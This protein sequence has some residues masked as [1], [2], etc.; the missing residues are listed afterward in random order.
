MNPG[1]A[2]AG[3]GTSSGT[4]N[5]VLRAFTSF[6]SNG[7]QKLVD[8]EAGVCVALLGYQYLKLIVEIGFTKRV[9][10]QALFAFIISLVWYQVARNSVAVVQVWMAFAGRFG[11][12]FSGGNLDG[13][14]MENPSLFMDLGWDALS[15]L[16]GQSTSF[17]DILAAGSAWVMFMIIGLLIWASFCLLGF[18]AVYVSIRCS[19]E[20]M[21][22]LALL[23]FV[24]VRETAF[25]AAAGIGMIVNAWVKLSGTSI[26]IGVSYG[27]VQT[28]KL[29][30]D[31]TIRQGA[32]LLVVAAACVLISGG[33]VM[34]RAAL[35]ALRVL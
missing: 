35:G 17:T 9:A 20:V 1:D 14:V 26:A 19:L 5:Y 30:P 33:V 28:I 27:V 6:I 31:A 24:I 16:V 21:I 15:R 13:N 8:L 29:P 12:I 10:A 32:E 7:G 34:M 23:P 2:F 3:L 25:L 18:F 4:L 11:S 22:G